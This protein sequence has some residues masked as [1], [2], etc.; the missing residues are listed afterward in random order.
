M[1]LKGSLV[2][3]R[4]KSWHSHN[5]N[6]VCLGLLIACGVSKGAG[7]LPP[8]FLEVPVYDPSGN[9]LPFKIASVAPEGEKNLDLFTI[10]QTEYR[11]VARGNRLYFSKRWIGNR[12][13]DITLENDKG[14]TW[15]FSVPLMDCQ[16]RASVEY[17][18]SGKGYPAAYSIITGRLT[19]C[20]LTGD[21]WI[22]AM[23]MFGELDSPLLHEGFIHATDGT[24]SVNSSMKGERHILVVGKDK[25]PVRAFGVDV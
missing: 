1:F 22:R 15:V 14:V 12:R 5:A 9:R 19:G 23:P 20:K 10:R 2:H 21:W 11:V 3:S 24:F 6:L 4:R 18:R 7:P 8:C 25:Q 16:Q 13:L 17:G